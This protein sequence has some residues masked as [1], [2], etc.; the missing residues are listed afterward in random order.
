MIARSRQ[1][2]K[3]ISTTDH[4]RK[5]QSNNVQV[6]SGKYNVEFSFCRQFS[7]S[8]EGGRD[9]SEVDIKAITNG[10]P[11]LEHKLKVILLEAEVMRQEGKSVPDNTYIS[12]SHWKELLSLPSRSAR[13]RMYEYLFKLS[14]K[15][16]NRIA[17]KLEKKQQFEEFKQQRTNEV[18]DVPI[19]EFAHTYDL[20]HNNMF[21][22]IYESTINNLYNSKLIQAIT[23]GQKV[24]VD[25]GYDD[26]MTK[27]E[28]LNCA[29]QLMYMF[30][31]NRVHKGNGLKALFKIFFMFPL[32]S[33]IYNIFRLSNQRLLSTTCPGY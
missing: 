29:K 19:E 6:F 15:K 14:K 31:Q 25:C 2:L 20:K 8:D 26:N 22:R 11:E 17:K 32:L 21:L 3:I 30:A 24:V 9:E 23:Y 27:R 33:F 12:E 5:L 13:R 28:N 4:I 18:K 16:E 7:H 1:L 10:D